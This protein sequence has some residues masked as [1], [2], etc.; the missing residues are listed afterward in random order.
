MPAVDEKG[1]TYYRI[2]REAEFDGEQYQLIAA[3]EEYESSL[4]AHGLPLEETTSPLADPD[5]PNGTYTYEPH[6]RR[7]WYL[8]AIEKKEKEFEKNP[9]RAR[10]YGAVRVERT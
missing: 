4:G 8:D 3:L 1:A 6:V 9:S 2:E 5:N 7:D 10:V